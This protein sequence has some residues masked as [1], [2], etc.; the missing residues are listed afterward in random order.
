MGKYSIL[1][2]FSL[3]VML[4]VVFPNIHRLGHQSVENYVNYAVKSQAHNLAVS[5]A[6]AAAAQLY[7]DN[8]WR[9]GYANIALAGG[10]YDVSATTYDV[11][12]VKI[13]SVGKLEDASDTVSVLLQPGSFARYAYY[14]KV[15]GSITWITGDTVWG[16]FHTQ[17]VM[18]TAGNPVLKGPAT[19]LL[20][21]NPSK[22][23][24]KFDGGY[25]AG[26]SVDLP[27]DLSVTQKAA[28][29][30]GSVFA[31]GDVWITFMGSTVV[32][33]TS[34]AGAITSAPLSTFAPN[35]VVLA[36]AGSFYIKGQIDGRLTL[37]AG[38]NA[39]LAQ[40]NIYI[41]GDM[42]YAHDPRLEETTNILGLI[43]ENS[44]IILDNAANNNSV[45]IQ[46]SI[47]CRTGGLTAENYASRP[48]S[49]T[50]DL[51]G[52]IIQYKRGAV[53]TFSSSGGTPVIKTGFKKN[54]KYD[55]R[56]YLDSPP[57]Y[58]WTGSY[59]IVSWIE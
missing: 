3:A 35:G 43:A 25:L 20:G 36:E 18:K 33:K 13:L 54:Y 30:G 49:G 29:D 47:F 1:M 19:A 21:T 2:V 27:L 52:G 48:V 24:A 9:T 58:P 28:Y 45:S 7:L 8:G 11:D 53:G 26:E 34:A 40:G 5:G 46:A 55:T 38:G 15:E 4:G 57:Y 14:S 42:M 50:L 10:T 22:S 16:P 17:D 23:G 12:K 6:N 56:L 51:L 39:S 59:Q 41:E 32:W 44:V 31:S 37:C